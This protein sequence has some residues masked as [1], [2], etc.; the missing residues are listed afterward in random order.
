MRMRRDV[1]WEAWGTP[2]LPKRLLNVQK[3]DDGLSVVGE[4]GGSCG[5]CQPAQERMYVEPAKCIDRQST[6]MAF[7]SFFFLLQLIV[8]I[9][10]HKAVTVFLVTN[11]Y[12]AFKVGF[13]IDCATEL[14][15]RERTK[16]KVPCLY[17]LDT[18]TIKR[19]NDM[20]CCRLSGLKHRLAEN[21]KNL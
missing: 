12:K 6:G 11:Y 18:H 19:P 20:T 5:G 14:I 16:C 10:S 3:T 17:S 4:C 15:L 2:K 21:P 8:I 9:T 1:E 7:S 13:V